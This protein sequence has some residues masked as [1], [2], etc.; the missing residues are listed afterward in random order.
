M[1]A[2]KKCSVPMCEKKY[3]CKGFCNSHHYRHVIKGYPIGYVGEI[4][5]CSICDKKHFCNTFCH[6][7]YIKHVRNEISLD[8]YVMV[9]KNGKRMAEHQFV[10]SKHL[11]RSLRKGENVHHINGIKSDNRIENLELWSSNQP[12]GQRIEDKVKWAKQ[13]LELYDNEELQKC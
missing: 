7:H 13:I 11:R 3:Y 5:K 9:T 1:K 4:T 10:M 8:K 12:A 6:H 2:I